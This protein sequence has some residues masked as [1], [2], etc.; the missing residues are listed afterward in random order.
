MA[1]ELRAHGVCALTVTPGFMRTEVMLDALGVTESNWRDGARTD[2]SF[3]H[4]ETPLYVGRAVAALAA[5]PNVLAKSG[6]LYSSWGLAREYGFTDVDGA[7]PDIGTHLG[8]LFDAPTRTG[9][10]WEIRHEGSGGSKGSGGS[11][12]STGSKRR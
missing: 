5:D 3:V 9:V 12:G 2:P 8:H 11:G 4:S 1:E 6:G 10:R 7:Q